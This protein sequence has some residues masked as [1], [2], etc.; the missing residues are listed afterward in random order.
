MMTSLVL[1]RKLYNYNVHEY[2]KEMYKR[3]C[4]IISLFMNTVE[5]NLYEIDKK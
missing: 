5:E 2:N 3:K 4:F 1:K